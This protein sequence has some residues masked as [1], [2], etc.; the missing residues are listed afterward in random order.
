MRKSEKDSIPPALKARP[1]PE[2]KARLEA[3]VLKVFSEED[4][5]RADMR[6]I[7]KTAG[8][9]FETIYKYYGSKEKLLFAFVAEWLD[10]LTEEAIRNIEGVE[11]LKERIRILVWTQL[12]Y[13]QRNPE[14]AKIVFLTVPNAAWVADGSFEQTRFVNI[15]LDTMREGQR[16]GL[17][18]PN[19]RASLLLDV[20]YGIVRRCFGMWV[21]R[22]E[23]ESFTAQA[24]SIFEVIWGGISKPTSS[25]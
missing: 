14:M 13:Y 6:S 3:A 19:A 8:V 7:A 5:H 18:N 1:S 16:K 15:V 21:Y 10:K 11:D 4:F 24:D 9:S 23:T 17:L 25:G 12:D 2:I 20:M 22:G